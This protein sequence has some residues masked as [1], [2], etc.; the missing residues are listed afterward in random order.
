L[1]SRADFPFG[2]ARDGFR[3]RLLR[4]QTEKRL[5]DVMEVF[6]K[7]RLPID[8]PRGRAYLERLMRE[9]G[10]NPLSQADALADPAPSDRGSAAAV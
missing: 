4:F 9:A 10:L 1:C 2:I 5:D 7:S 8:L 3:A 6:R